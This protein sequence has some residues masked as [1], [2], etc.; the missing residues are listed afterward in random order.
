VSH[1]T[2]PTE[3]WAPFALR[4]TCGPLELRAIRDEDIPAL[5]DLALGG[6]HEPEQMPFAFPWT[7]APAD[8]LPANTAAYYWTARTQFS[9]ERWTLD[10]AVRVD[11]ELVGVQG[12][13]TKTYLVVRTG[14]TGSWLGRSFQGRGIGTAMRQAMCA[15]LFDHLDAHEITSGAFVDNPASLAVSRKVGYVDNGTFRMQRRPGELAWN[16]NLLLTPDRFVRAP[17]P[18]EVD[19]VAPLRRA[20]GLDPL[21]PGFPSGA[22]RFCGKFCLHEG[23]STSRQ[24]THSPSGR[25]RAADRRNH[26]ERLPRLGDIVRTEHARSEPRRHRRRSERSDQSLPHRTIQRL[27]HEVLVRQRHQ[28][29]PPGRHQLR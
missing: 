2:T 17:H 5:V 15:L 27:A 8:K 11:G 21:Q 12:F 29:R 16:R 9:P 13:T 25:T 18:V 14:E 26:V 19:G 28:H 22:V 4:V 6:I 7:D 10:L 23:G 24:P 1:V 3:L 20:I